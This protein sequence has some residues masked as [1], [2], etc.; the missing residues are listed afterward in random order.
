[1]L[2]FVSPVPKEQ[3]LEIAALIEA[4]CVGLKRP[5]KWVNV[6]K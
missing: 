2:R 5:D 4:S 1:M 3:T 6:P